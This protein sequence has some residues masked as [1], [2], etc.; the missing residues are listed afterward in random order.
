MEYKLTIPGTLPSLNE[1]I[2]AMNYNRHAGNK[3]KQENMQI[4]GWDIRQQLKGV[5]IEKPVRIKFFWYERNRKRDIDNVCSMGRKVILDALV[6]QG[7]LQ[8]DNQKWIK[9]FEDTFDVDEKE[10]RIEVVI[11]EVE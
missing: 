11:V 1:Y 8:N 6:E 7:V 10:P 9:G 2:A 3:M 4:V 5:K